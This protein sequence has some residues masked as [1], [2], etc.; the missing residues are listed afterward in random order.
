MNLIQTLKDTGKAIGKVGAGAA[1]LAM[2]AT[3]AFARQPPEYQSLSNIVGQG[4]T[5][6]D[7][8]EGLTFGCYF[9]VDRNGDYG[10]NRETG[11]WEGLDLIEYRVIKDRTMMMWEP[12]PYAIIMD[13]DFDG[14]ADW[15][16]VDNG[17][18]DGLFDESNDLRGKKIKMDEINLQYRN[19]MAV[20]NPGQLRK[21]IIEGITEDGI[22]NLSGEEITE[23]ITEEQE[24]YDWL[25]G[26]P[27]GYYDLITVNTPSYKRIYRTV[28]KEEDISK[29]DWKY[30]WNIHA[31]Y[32]SIDVVDGFEIPTN[33]LTST[34][35]YYKDLVSPHGR[36]FVEYTFKDYDSDGTLESAKRDFRLSQTDEDG[37]D[38]FFYFMFP[39]YPKGFVNKDWFT[40]SPELAQEKYDKEIDYWQEVMNENSL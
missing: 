19:P 32:A 38:A 8:N 21:E 2:L 14:F 9:K 25:M 20:P 13:E 27:E 36:N 15:E 5:M 31:L 17:T 40:P 6:F 18:R 22:M 28:S 23:E 26:K 11:Q 1:V 24:V 33:D 16:Y 37:D 34:V 30:R 39:D 29:F 3:P 4:M 12:E 35:R 10:L 7:T